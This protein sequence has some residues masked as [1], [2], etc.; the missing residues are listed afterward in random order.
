MCPKKVFRWKQKHMEVNPGSLNLR[1]YGG[2]FL[3]K[4]D[5]DVSALP[6]CLPM[7]YWLRDILT[8]KK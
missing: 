6:R 8:L 7:F 5:Y 1:D 4:C 2:S 3:S